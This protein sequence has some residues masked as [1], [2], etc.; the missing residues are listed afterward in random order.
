MPTLEPSRAGFTMSGRPSSRDRAIAVGARRSARSSA[1][2]GCPRPAASALGAPLVH[3]ERRAHA[4]RCRCT[5]CRALER[6]LHRAVLAEAAVQRDEHALEAAR[7]SSSIEL[8]LGADRTACASTPSRAQRLEHPL[9]VI[10]RDSRA[11][12][13][14][15]HQH[16]DLA[17]HAV[18]IRRC[19]RD[20][21]TS[22]SR[23]HAAAHCGLPDD[24]HFGLQAAR[25]AR[26][27]PCLHV[28]RSAPRCRPPSPRRR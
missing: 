16:R 7:A 10:E 13:T 27:R 14:A 18:G 3:G 23:A 22:A 1:A 26:A 21:V 25:R 6:A 28:A 2:S 5:A 12:R 4:R 20:C 8:A 15:A 9:P 19:G 11:R 17:E 24:A